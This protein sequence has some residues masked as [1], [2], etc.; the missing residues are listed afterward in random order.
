MHL[1]FLKFI[2]RSCHSLKCKLTRTH[3]TIKIHVYT[4][5]Q[6][7][8]DAITHTHT[9]GHVTGITPIRARSSSIGPF[10]THLPD[11]ELIWLGTCDKSVWTGAAAGDA[12]KTSNVPASVSR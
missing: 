7:R 11:T 8:T 9:N 4:T 10:L 5:I 2:Y 6:A 1:N 3:K 12:A